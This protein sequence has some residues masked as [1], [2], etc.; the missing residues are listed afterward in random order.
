MENISP[1]DFAA[2]R[3]Q[4]K[5]VHSALVGNPVT[6]DGGMVKRLVAAED[7][8]EKVEKLGARIGWHFKVMY[9]TVG[10]VAAG[11][12]ELLTKK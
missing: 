4:L 3:Q 12:W 6:G 9:V 1:E 10:F 5:D 8:I 7:R 11:V 2:M